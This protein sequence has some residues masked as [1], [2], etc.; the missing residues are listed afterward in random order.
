M[1]FTDCVK[2]SAALALAA[3]AALSPFHAQGQTTASK[4]LIDFANA[5]A[6]SSV[7][8][9]GKS[10]AANFSIVD[11]SGAKALEVVCPV[12]D[13]GYPGVVLLPSGSPVWDLSANGAVAVKVFN[14]GEKSLSLNLRVDSEGDWRDNPWNATS[15]TVPAGKAVEGRVTFGFSFG[16]PAFKLDSSKVK[17]IL[18]FTGKSK[19]ERKF[20]ILSALAVGEPGEKPVGFA[21]HVKPANGQLFNLQGQQ[22][23]PQIETRG[24]TASIADGAIKISVLPSTKEAYPTVLCKAPKSQIIDLSEYLKVAFTVKNEGAEP[25]K[26]KLRVDSKNS[27]GTD[28]CAAAPM[29]SIAPGESKTVEVKFASDKPWVKGEKNSGSRISS[30]D[31]MGI[32][33]IF[34]KPLKGEVRLSVSD[35]KAEMEFAEIPDWLGKRPPVDGDWKLTFED[36]FDG[37]A[38]DQ[39]KWSY[40]G[41]N[42]WDKQSHWSKDNVIVENGVAKLRYEAKKGFHNDDPKEKSSDYA[43]GFLESYGKWTQLYGYFEARMKL[44]PAPGLWPAFWL[45]PDRG[46]AAGPQWK[47]QDTANGAM[48]FDVMENLTRWGVNRYNIAMHW[49]GYSKD[50]KMGGH[51]RVYIAPDKD[52]FITCGVLWTPGS[53]IYYCNGKE[54]LRWVDERVS[55]V[56]S[57]MMFTLPLGGWDNNAIDKSKLPADFIIDY[58]RVWQRKDLESSKP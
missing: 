16:K 8:V 31:V 36:N 28:N 13:E 11:S 26:F 53:A 22:P 44:P 32:A 15:F 21:E 56:Q 33:I 37:N 5:D 45:M 57:N 41:P 7:K 9:N 55:K 1:N 40:Y 54:V 52:G 38:I 50:H 3:F 43:A 51:D 14:P 10:G 6:L 2:I 4:S 39:S 42:F 47:R 18:V 24:A 12:S 23:A 29:D 34:E 25:A 49:D 19:D 35:I 46:V 30:V 17:K 48:E 58:V 20:V 27:N